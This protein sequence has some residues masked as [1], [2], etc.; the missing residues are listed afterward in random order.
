M[1]QQMLQQGMQLHQ[2]GHLAEAEPLYAKVLALQPANYAVL[3]LMGL[4][5]LQQNRLAEALPLMEKALAVNPGAPETL[6]NYAIALD[7]SGRRKE[8]LAAFTK[9]AQAHPGKAGIWA[10][11]GALLARMGRMEAAL[12]DI[13]RALTLDPRA[14]SVMANRGVV[15]R[16]LGRPEEALVAYDRALALE[17]GN[18]DARNDRGLVLMD[19]HRDAEALAEFDRILAVAPGKADIW[20]NRA[21]SLW[22]LERIDEALAA[23]DRTLALNPDQVAARISRGDLLWARRNALGPAIADLEQAA[24]IA[25]E[26]EDLL[27][28]LFH[29]KM[30]AG[31][32]R[33]FDTDRTALDA[34]AR[35]GRLVAKPF[36]YAGIAD[37]PAALKALIDAH[38]A[39]DFPAHPPLRPYRER[40]RRAGKI[41]VAYLCGEFRAQATAY[42]AAGLFERHDRGQFEIL[43][44]DNTAPDDSVMRRRLEAAFDGNM[45]DITRLSDAD[46]AAAVAAREPDI[47]VNL[48]GYFGRHRMGLCAWRPAP[49]QVSYLGFPATLGAEYFDYIL[50][51]ATVIP[52]GAERFFREKVARLPH[53]Y[54]INDDGREIASHRPG[55]A[56]MGLPETGFVFSHFNYSYKITPILFAL[57]MRLLRQVEG[58]VL[59]LLETHPLFKDN[60]SATA[61]QAGIDPARIIWA[62]QVAVEEHL[63]RLAAADLF[64]DSLPCNAHTTASDALWAGLPL[65]TCAGAVFGARVA[66]SLLQAVGLPELVTRDL[67]AYEALGLSLAREPA[68][69][70][71]LR[72][73]LADN[74]ARAPLFDTA[75]TTRAIEA[76]YRQMLAGWQDGEGPQHFAV[77]E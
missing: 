55:R 2:A 33:S 36:I 18:N 61:A 21:A 48:N 32:W 41:R 44:V 68:R 62:P 47:L 57:W 58:S 77:E 26:Y 42:L 46:A 7:Q 63:A 22:H 3:H 71:A 69:L 40:Q 34:G 64:L 70:A 4:L 66:A 11:R 76:A 37:D 13:D 29:L 54:Q 20:V 15:L 14:A 19:L 10:N 75:R 24:R 35:A 8:S 65:I 51:D 17:P 5:R 49:I 43:A 28:D 73:R 72:Q 59:W 25:P 31:D 60:I 45:L 27:G 53:S 52:P 74:R 56:A 16:A 50:A 9:L 23:Y 12:A 38:T 39:Q 6:T 1:I 67:E 30:Y